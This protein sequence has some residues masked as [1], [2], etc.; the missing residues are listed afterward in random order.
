MSTIIKYFD[1]IQMYH[2]EMSNGIAL[3]EKDSNTAIPIV[4]FF[5]DMQH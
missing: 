1:S 2:I 3:S 5:D 4:K